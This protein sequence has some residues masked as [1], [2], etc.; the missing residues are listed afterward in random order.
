METSPAAPPKSAVRAVA[1]PVGRLRLTARGGALIRVAWDETAPDTTGG[2]AEDTALLDEAAAQLG[3]Y[4]AG[5][6][7]VFDLPLAPA[8]APFHR[9]V[10]AAMARI[11]YGRMRTYGDLAREVGGAARAV[12]Q[13]CGANP[14]PIVIP[15]HRVVAGGGRLGGFSG[16]L[17]AASKRRLL[18]HERA[19]P[20]GADLFAPKSPSPESAVTNGPAGR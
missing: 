20:E 11:P 14:I 1:T 15:C 10:W 13:A 8:G 3:A 12:G 16:G 18:A 4:F 6:L 17:G 19:V 7:T 5:G 9:R 2:D